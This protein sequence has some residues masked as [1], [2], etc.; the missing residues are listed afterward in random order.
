MRRIHQ[1]IQEMDLQ[2]QFGLLSLLSRLINRMMSSCASSTLG[3]RHT[4]SLFNDGRTNIFF[5]PDAKPV[6][7]D[8]KTCDSLSIYYFLQSFSLYIKR[9]AKSLILY[10]YAVQN[11]L[12]FKYLPFNCMYITRQKSGIK[13]WQRFYYEF[14]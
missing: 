8:S 1:K 11:Y 10:S 2:A 9:K 12:I 6:S 4:L 7:A 14:L 3:K 5:P 13:W